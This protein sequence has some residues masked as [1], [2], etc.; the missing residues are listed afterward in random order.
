LPARARELAIL[1]VAAAEDS[2]FERYAHEAV[3]ADAGVPATVIAA[4]RTGAPIELDDDVERATIAA[5]RALAAD[6]DLDDDAYAAAVATL[7][8]CGVFELT[9]LVGYYRTLALQLRVFRVGVPEGS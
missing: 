1:A 7:G 5:A 9:T 2:A 3:A 8:E 6:G 4:V